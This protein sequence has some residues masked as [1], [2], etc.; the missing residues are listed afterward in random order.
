[1]RNMEKRK[2]LV[3]GALSFG[4]LGVGLDMTVLNVAIPTLATQL[5]ATT[6]DLQ[7]IADSFNLVMAAMLLPAG[8]LGDRYGRKK[9]LLLALVIFGLASI[10][11]AYA[12]TPAALIAARTALGLGAAF[13]I[14][15]SMSALPVLFSGQERTKAM[16]IWATANMMGIPLGPILGGWLLKHYSW[17]SVF[18]INIPFVVV[19][20]VAVGILMP[21]SRSE[22]RTHLD[23][24]GV[25]LSS[26]GLAAITYGVIRG[27]EQGWSDS[28]VY[29][30]MA[31]GIVVILLFVRRQRTTVHPLIDISLFRSA[32]FTWGT[33]LATLVNFALFGL[34]FAMPQ[35]FQAVQGQD[36]FS[37]GLRLLPLIGGLIIGARLSDKLMGRLGSKL[38]A[39]LGFILIAAGLM[40]G[41]TTH[42]DS[43]YGLAVL[44]FT[45]TGLGLGMSLPT[46]M[47]AALG[48]LSAERSGVG[49]ALIM[50]LRQ[51]GGAIGVAVLGAV[52]SSRYRDGL[53]LA[54]L[55]DAA[56]GA[57]RQSVS[58]GVAVSRK[59]QADVVLANVQEAFVKGMSVMLWTCAGIALAGGILALLFLPRHS[60]GQSA[61][62]EDAG[63]VLKL[64]KETGT[65]GE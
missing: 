5:Q 38:N 12:G 64:S 40:I 50:A 59:L 16:M 27:G 41:T 45:I 22:E 65:L 21:E 25:L 52:L 37:T 49:S 32:S 60:G 55:P 14:P 13:L 39:T 63:A 47:D 43:A 28:L 18:L 61:D 46:A 51:V 10:G 11:C 26:S 36:T 2:W 20:L 44:W 35:F 17:G 57:V 34:L 1:M 54:G 30:S 15:L 48:T 42:T 23:L 29:L 8:M 56:A 53:E 3:L 7:W 19:A 33:V 24:P 9:L 58:V 6:G 62:G 31:A 4:L